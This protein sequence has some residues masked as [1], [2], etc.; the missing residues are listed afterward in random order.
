MRDLLL[1]FSTPVLL[2][3][4]IGGSA[5]LMVLVTYF[6]R[7]R[8]SEQVHQANNEVAGFILGVVGVIYGVLLAFMV[9]VVWQ[10]YQDAQLTV[11]NEANALVQVYRLGQEIPEPYGSRIRVLSEVYAQQVVNKEWSEISYGRSSSEVG[12]TVEM[13]W[14]LHRQMHTAN[15]DT[16]ERES[17]LFDALDALGN[18]RRIRLLES[19]L[20]IPALLYQL[21]ILGGVVTLGFTLFLRAP[22]WKAHLLMAAMFAGLVAF[23]LVLIIELDNPFTG[24]IRILP[25]AFQQALET[26]ARLRGN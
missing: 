3:L 24:D 25:L 14:T 13:L 6:V 26:F 9:L 12:D 20:D 4:V 11:E 1:T 17:K 8:V 10:L 19:R 5:M 22:N 2:T 18:Y 15:A 16:P 23:V 7:S 21:L